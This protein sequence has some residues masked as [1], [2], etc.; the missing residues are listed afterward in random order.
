MTDEEVR[1][2]S[3]VKITN[4]NL[5]DSVGGPIPGGLYDPA[6]GPL[7]DA[8]SCK[9]CGL[10]SFYCNGH[11]GHIDLVSPAYNPLLFNMLNILLNKTC[12]Y[13]FHFKSRRKLVETCVAQL[14]L[15][16]RGDIV[17]ARKLGLK[18]SEK[19]REK[20]GWVLDD[21]VDEEDSRGSYTSHSTSNKQEC[22]DSSQLTEAMSVMNEFLRRK[23]KKC[24]NCNCMSPKI[25]IPTFGWF[26]LVCLF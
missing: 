14:E 7:D 1:R 26:H 15:I 4:P 2:H 24:S 3:F 21:I 18:L 12:L 23:E 10:R 6:M 20:M 9:S 19:H 13:C 17:G 16:S 25:K 5:L 22:W 8:S 11:C